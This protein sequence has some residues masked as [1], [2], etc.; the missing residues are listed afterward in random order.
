MSYGLAN[1]GPAPGD[2]ARPLHGSE[3][4]ARVDALRAIAR[5]IPDPAEY[6]AYLPDWAVTAMLA[7]AKDHSD[8]WCAPRDAAAALRPLGLVGYGTRGLT[9]FGWAVRQALLRD[10]G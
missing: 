4:R 7:S 8:D 1:L 2:L 5:D 9:A 10:N 3:G 6:A